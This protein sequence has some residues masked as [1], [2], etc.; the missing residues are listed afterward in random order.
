ML[1]R[2]CQAPLSP[3][4]SVG[5]SSA[6]KKAAR[7]P[8]TLLP[9]EVSGFK[10][11]LEDRYRASDDNGAETGRWI[12][13]TGSAISQLW[14]EKTTMSIDTCRRIAAAI[15]KRLYLGLAGDE[16]PEGMRTIGSDA[17]SREA[18]TAAATDFDLPHWVVAELYRTPVPEGWPSLTPQIC[19]DL[20]AVWIKWQDKVGSRVRKKVTES[21]G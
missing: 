14:S 19:H 8:N 16:P 20:A 13:V 5:V 11:I 9:S 1:P 21:S 3:A 17:A 12:G 18:L 4:Y 15:G 7:N 10:K 2:G 6:K